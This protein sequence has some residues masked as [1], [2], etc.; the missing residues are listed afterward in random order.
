MRNLKFKAIA[1]SSVFLM[2]G[3]AAFS[4][5]AAT[6]GNSALY[7]SANKAGLSSKVLHEA[8][9]GYDWAKAQGKV[10]N[11]NVLT[12]V[13]FSKPSTQKRLYVFNLKTD[14]LLILHIMLLSQL[15]L[16]SC[17]YI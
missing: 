5:H 7:T 16:Q 12:V 3:M 11:P 9:K 17:S 8:I 14:K 4:A 2:T 1:L 6:I 15:V 10:K 13:D